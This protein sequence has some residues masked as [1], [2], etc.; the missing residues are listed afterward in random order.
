MAKRSIK[1]LIFDFDGLIL[2]TEWP[3]YQNWQE[4][5]RAH[6]TELPIEMWAH[7]VG[8]GFTEQFEPF[9]YLEGLIGKAVDR[10]KLGAEKHRRDTELIAQQPVLP[11]V[12]PIL[13]RAKRLKFKT[14]VASSSSLAWVRGHLGRHG[15]LDYF[16]VLRT[17]DDVTN[18]KPDP[19]LFLATCDA[20]NVA[21]NEAIIFEDSPNGV[22]AARRAGIFVVA[23]PNPVTAQMVI[24][25]PN[26]LITSLADL[27][28][29]TLIAEV[30]NHGATETGSVNSVHHGN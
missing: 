5:F 27:S 8:S 13:Q 25:A 15:L 4:I 21:P 19:E 1:A 10:E 22:L 28:L 9:T 16:D 20:L 23:V 18:I 30:E 14:A 11:G 26:L 24:E 12:V 3:E 6:G 29:E 17:R 7:A 2:D